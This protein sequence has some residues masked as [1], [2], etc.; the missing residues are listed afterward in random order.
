V[1]LVDLVDQLV[2]VDSQDL[3]AYHLLAL[4]DSQDSLGQLVQVDLVDL[5]DQLVLQAS[6]DLVEFQAA[7][8]SII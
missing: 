4:A 6:V 7:D 8:Q 1:D 3:V 5:V 2:Q